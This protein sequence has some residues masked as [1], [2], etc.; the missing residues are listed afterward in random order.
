[1]AIQMY[2]VHPRQSDDEQAR[3]TLA[4]LVVSYQGFIL[5]ATSYGSLIVALDEQ[6]VDT[7]K[8]HHLVAFVGGVTLNPGGA[9]AERLQHLFAHNVAL[10]L[11]SRGASPAVQ[12]GGAD[13]PTQE[14]FPAGYRPLRWPRRD[15]TTEGG[16]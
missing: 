15:S 14:Q 12:M 16:D 5:M 4:E 3:S 7:L 11:Q 10:Q 1:M 6:Y 13:A 9:A 2:L 8:A